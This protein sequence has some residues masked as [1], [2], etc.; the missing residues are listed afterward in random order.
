MSK[1]YSTDL[2]RCCV[3]CANWARLGNSISGECRCPLPQWL[4]ATPF[5]EPIML[6]ADGQQCDAFEPKPEQ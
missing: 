2:D 4:D 5:R 6:D 3:N 1:S